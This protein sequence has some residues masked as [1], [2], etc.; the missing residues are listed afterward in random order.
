MSRVNLTV[1]PTS[2]LLGVGLLVAGVAV[3]RG[4]KA[5]GDAVDWVA[6][7][8]QRVTEYARE[9]GQTFL[10]NQIQNEL[11]RTNTQDSYTPVYND[12]LKNDDGM[13]FRYF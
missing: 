10:D 4:Q 7:I 12:P 5:L 9:G 2:I 6:S 11:N 1:T 13:D 8:P 3:W